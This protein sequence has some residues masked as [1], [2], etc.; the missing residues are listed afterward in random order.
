MK[1]TLILL[2]GY[3]ATGKSY[4][5]S[6]ICS[7]H[8]E[9]RILSQDELKEGLWDQYGFDNMEEKT[10]LEMKSWELYY[11][12]M[13]QEMEA[14]EQI[15]SDYPFSEKQKGR[16]CAL[17]EKNRYQV[18]TFRLVGDIDTLYQRSRGRDLAPDRHLGHLVSRYHKG[19]SMEDRSRA[20]CLVT[21]EVFRD[22]CLNRGYDT[23]ELGYLLEIDV[24]EYEKID[25]PGI[26]KQLCDLLEGEEQ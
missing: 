25:Y 12:K 10:V 21:Q 24:T 3:P 8:P 11:E 14:G 1:K 4:L 23:F 7:K 22:R 16:I 17:A 13:D 9:F 5:C 20:D 19:D 6:Q 18:V 2:A 26:L 15:I